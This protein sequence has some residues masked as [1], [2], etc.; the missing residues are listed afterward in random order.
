VNHTGD[1]GWFELSIP[2]L[3]NV[4]NSI[5]AIAVARELE[6]TSR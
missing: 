4:S 1:L 2:G 3:H 6:S 5:A